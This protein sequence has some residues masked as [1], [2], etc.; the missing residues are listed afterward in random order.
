MKAAGAAPFLA[1]AIADLQIR[2]VRLLAGDVNRRGPLYVL[3]AAYGRRRLPLHV[4]SS[5]KMEMNLIFC[6]GRFAPHKRKWSTSFDHFV[7]EGEQCRYGTSRSSALALLR[8]KREKLLQLRYPTP[9]RPK[10][11][12]SKTK[13]AANPA[14]KGP[15]HGEGAVEGF[16]LC[17]ADKALC[18]IPALCRVPN[19]TGSSSSSCAYSTV[20]LPTIGLLGDLPHTTGRSKLPLQGLYSRR[21]TSQDYCLYAQPAFY[22]MQIGIRRGP[23]VVISTMTG[24]GQNLPK[25]RV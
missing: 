1:S 5:P 21:V 9:A 20:I 10:T 17:T 8:S 16:G 15:H 6:F 24:L 11:R 4:R 12:R 19:S 23:A 18:S 2:S 25:F 3:S 7:N 22:M 14:A 13:C